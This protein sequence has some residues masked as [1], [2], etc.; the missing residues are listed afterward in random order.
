MLFAGLAFINAC[1]LQNLSVR[2]A[3]TSIVRLLLTASTMSPGNCNCLEELSD[4]R[5]QQVTASV[6]AKEA[7][8]YRQDGH[9]SLKCV[10]L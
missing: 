9:S 4:R 10:L 3:S 2:P 5:I 7:M 8:S 6:L 1:T